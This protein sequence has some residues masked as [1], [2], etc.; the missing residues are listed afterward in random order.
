MNLQVRARQAKYSA[1]LPAVVCEGLV[2]LGHAVRIFTLADR[3]AAALSGIHQL[4]RETERHG[5][6]AAVASSLDDPAHSQCLA[7][8]GANFNRDLVSGTTDAAGLHL[9]DRLH[10]VE[11]GRQNVNG[12]RTLLTGLLADA[13]ERAVNDAL[14]GGLLAALHDDVNELRQHIVVELRVREDGEDRSLGST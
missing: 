2:G 10:V 8:S 7:A 9:D 3:G 6:L 4:V 1:E 14:G 13:V 12:L 11:S 5:L